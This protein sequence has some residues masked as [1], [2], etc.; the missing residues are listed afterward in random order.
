[1]NINNSIVQLTQPIEASVVSAKGTLDAVEVTLNELQPSLR[2]LPLLLSSSRQTTQ[3]ITVLSNQ[4]ASHW[5][6][7]GKKAENQNFE[8][9]LLPD[10]TMYGEIKSSM[11]SSESLPEKTLQKE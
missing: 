3:S 8:P 2:V 1:M 4:L 10:N 5:L 6:L 7:G 9:L 11:G